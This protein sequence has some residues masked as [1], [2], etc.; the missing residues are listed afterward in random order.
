MERDTLMRN[1]IVL[2]TFYDIHIHC[3]FCGTPATFASNGGYEV[4]GCDHLLFL[5]AE[6]FHMSVSKRLEAS[7]KTRGWI[8]ERQE[9]GLANIFSKDEHE[10]VNILELITDFDDAILIEQQDGPPTLMSS[11]TAFA[12]S[13]EDYQRRYSNR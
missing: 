9:D 2:D 12:Y 3:P 6:E 13:D 1:H 8:L 10:D 11:F 7:I 5:T 4:K